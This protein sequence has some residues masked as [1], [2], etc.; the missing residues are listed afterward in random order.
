[1][2]R[3][4]ERVMLN[5]GLVWQNYYEL[6]RNPK[7]VLRRSLSGVETLLDLQRTRGNPF[8]QRLAQRKLSVSQPGD[9]CEQEADRI[10]NAVMHQTTGQRRIVAGA[11]DSSTDAGKKRKQ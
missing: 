10:A 6:S 7:S 4:R 3:K 8:V 1:M 11:V 9:Q 5:R 2:T